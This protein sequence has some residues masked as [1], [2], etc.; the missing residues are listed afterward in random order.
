MTAYCLA[1]A[2]QGTYPFGGR[3]RAVNDLGNQFVPFHARLWDLMH[4]EAH[5]DLFFNWASGYGT[6]FLADFFTYLMN[7]FSW[8]VGVFPRDTVEFPVFLVTLF[9][10]GLAA[11]LMTV[12]LGRLHEGSPW[13]RAL[14]S[15]GFALSAWMIS[16]GF[17][18][19]MWMWGL[20]ALPLLGIAYDDCLRRRRWVTGALLVAVCWG[21]NFYTAAMA[22]LGMGLVLLVRVVVDDGDGRGVRDVQEDGDA[23]DGRD[24]RDARDIRD[25]RDVRDARDARDGRD[26]PDGRDVRDGRDARDVR[27][28]LRVLARAATM[29]GAGI[30][31]AAPV[32]TVSLRASKLAQPAPE[33]VYTG[34]PAPLDYLA[35]LIP[36]GLVGRV[37][38]ISVGMLCLLLVATFPFIRRVPVKERI[39]WP[40]LIALIALSLVWE[41]TILLWHGLTLPN[42]SPYRASIALT[43]VLV[44]VAWLALARR[45]RVPELLA[46]AAVVLVLVLCVSTT[47][48]MTTGP[49]ILTAGG[50]VLLGLLL[51]LDRFRADRRVRR[52]LT[53]ALAGAVLLSATY[54]VLST[55]R[56][57]DAI[58]WW[59]PKRTFDRQALAAYDQLK[60]ADAWPT[61]RT[62]PG[63]HSFAANDPM[64]LA[65]QGG[66]YYS[67][68]LPAATADAL[69]RLGAAWYIEGRHTRSFEDPVGRAVMGVSSY[70]E[71]DGG[72]DGFVRRTATAPPVVT[73]RPAATAL[74]GTTRDVSLF[75]RQERVLGARVYEVPAVTRGAEG[76]AGG[77]EGGGR[78]GALVPGRGWPLKADGAEPGAGTTF[79]AV[80]TPGTEA[81]W[82]APWLRG[83]VDTLGGLAGTTVDAVGKY[84]MT[85][86]SLRSL[87]TVPA[88]G[89]VA[90][91]VHSAQRQYIPESP[92]GCLDRAALDRTVR[93]LRATGPDRVDATGHGITAAFAPGTQGTA[94]LSVPATPGWRCAVDGGH[95]RVPRTLG[96]LVAVELGDGAARLSCSYRTPGLRLGLAASGAAAALLFAV[97]AAHLIRTRTSRTS[98]TA[99]MS[100]TSSSSSSRSQRP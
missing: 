49:W 23:R 57:R 91:R 63:P 43:A 98:R 39:A 20:V 26:V 99:G 93:Q 89:A 27:T 53:V 33:A 30:L 64:L 51:A 54:T 10:A 32:L 96:G 71:P 70:L 12:F 56:I 61:S 24:V 35:H 46:G 88:D 79:T 67:S 87:G 62:D 37:P 15:V 50:V 55:T 52:G 48:Y 14:L 69:H 28:R 68:Y 74:D 58:E 76:E 1:M 16:D 77:R 40:V 72:P 90:V 3:S 80:C 21:G 83:R 59:K 25:V 22:T 65:G 31:L 81:Y 86:N 7:P 17:S 4:G 100:R 66:G 75:S 95:A 2:A 38:H 84:P 78:E 6:P 45:P 11:A 82:Y 47:A 41:P 8:L 29:T 97:A 34:P 42:G 44:C 18:D 36:G 9:S 60:S 73:L 13:L 85:S 5:G 94:V 92:V 19:P